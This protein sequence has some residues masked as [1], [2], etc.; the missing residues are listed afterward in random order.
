MPKSSQLQNSCYG[1][2][3]MRRIVLF[4]ED[5]GHEEFVS[6]LIERLAGEN[7]FAIKINRRSVRGGHGKVISELRAYLKNLQH[8]REG[9]PDLLVVV[10]DAN[11]KGYNERKKEV[12]EASEKYKDITICAIPDPHIERWLLLDSAAFKSVLGKGCQAP[13]QKC[14]RDRFKQLLFEAIQQAGISPILGGMEHATDI[15]NAMDLTRMEQ[16][17]PSSL[18]KFIKELKN[19]FNEWSRT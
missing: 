18:G 8:E 13:N 9:M 7:D 4:G 16:S 11:C 5:Y 3:L 10:T 17:D 6:A 1:V 15:V 12:D 14:S 2:T 19:K